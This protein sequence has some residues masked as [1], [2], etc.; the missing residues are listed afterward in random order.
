MNER[1]NKGSKTNDN[2]FKRRPRNSFLRRG[3]L[4]SLNRRVRNKES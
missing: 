4:F 3:I 2:E 1:K